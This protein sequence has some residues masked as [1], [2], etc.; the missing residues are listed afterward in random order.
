MRQIR[1]SIR[2]FKAIQSLMRIKENFKQKA[3]KKGQKFPHIPAFL[4]IDFFLE[5]G[6]LIK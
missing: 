3:G 2:L 1:Y 6:V 5:E 4:F